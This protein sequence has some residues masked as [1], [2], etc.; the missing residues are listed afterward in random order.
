MKLTNILAISIIFSASAAAFAQK[1]AK[2]PAAGTNLLADIKLEPAGTV[3]RKAQ[4]AP[5]PADAKKVEFAANVS[6][7]DYCPA[8][9]AGSG[10]GMW[11]KLLNAQGESLNPQGMASKSK[12]T[13]PGFALGLKH[14]ASAP[15]T[16]RHTAIVP[17]G[18]TQ[19][20]VTI[21]EFYSTG[22]LCA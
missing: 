13:T 12:T 3:L 1:P 9:T 10:T 8:P 2:P 16:D 19:I 18:A 11:I 4:T 20:E 5:L 6:C 22:V 7:A 14:K 17:P 21:T 15:V